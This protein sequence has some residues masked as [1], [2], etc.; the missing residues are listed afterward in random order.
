MYLSRP[1]YMF[2]RIVFTVQYTTARVVAE[3]SKAFKTV[4]SWDEYCLLCV[5][6]GIFTN[7]S[8]M[9]SK[10]AEM[11]GQKMSTASLGQTVGKRE[12]V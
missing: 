1:Q 12:Y 2:H 9:T 3:T 5:V 11:N 10:L 8:R 4:D 7:C 6:L